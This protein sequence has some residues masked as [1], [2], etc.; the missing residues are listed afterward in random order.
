MPVHYRIDQPPRGRH[1]G[2]VA[3]VSVDATTGKVTDAA[4]IM[5]WTIG[6]GW[7]GVLDQAR[8]GRYG[9]Q[10]D[11]LYPGKGL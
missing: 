1:Q 2:Y 8:R 10:V 7:D 6:R 3:A 11:R 5:R 4:P 9:W